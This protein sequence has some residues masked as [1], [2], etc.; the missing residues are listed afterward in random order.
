[1]PGYVYL[2][3]AICAEVVATISMKAQTG[4]SRPL[5]LL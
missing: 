5:P 1:M 3:I 2:A 4:F